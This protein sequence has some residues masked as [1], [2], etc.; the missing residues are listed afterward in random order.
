MVLSMVVEEVRKPLR[1]EKSSSIVPAWPGVVP[2]TPS[3]GLGHFK[4]VKDLTAPFIS[5][6]DTAAAEI[7]C[8]YLMQKQMPLKGY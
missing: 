4:T 1:G 3:I 8:I 5:P 2:V 6:R 7:I